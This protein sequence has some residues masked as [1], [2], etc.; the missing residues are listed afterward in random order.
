MHSI[1]KKLK[2]LEEYSH[3]PVLIEGETGTGKEIIAKYI[4]YENS[5]NKGPFI[6]LNCSNLS[7]EL[8]ESELFGY[9][10]GSFTGADSKGKEGKIKLAQNGTLF[11]DEITEL[12]LDLQAKLLR[13]IQERE[14]YKI[15]DNTKEILDTRIVIATN[16][17]IQE[18]ISEKSF[19]EDLYYRINICKVTIPPL[20]DRKDEIIPLSIFLLQNLR[21]ELGKTINLVEVDA[22]EELKNNTWPGN[23]RELKNFLT[24]LLL[25]DDNKTITCDRVKSLLSNENNK[26]ETIPFD[27]KNI[28]ISDE[29]L[30]L[31]EL[32]HEIIKKTLEKFNGNKS[33][34][35]EFLGISRIQL[36][37]RFKT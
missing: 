35:A 3:I 15:G 32:N 34:T 6:G 30:N 14:Y 37:G 22:L 36:Y 26:K 20:R 11:L 2:K 33:K 28:I 4:H 10:K 8:F 5:S 31:D 1:Y 24:K 21:N 18:L 25:F 17:N 13:V 12:S 23:V 16:K 9:G 7:K 27:F 19:R 29:P